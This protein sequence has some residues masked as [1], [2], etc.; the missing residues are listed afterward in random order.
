MS[1]EIQNCPH[2][3]EGRCPDDWE[4][5]APTSDRRV[6]QCHV[7]GHPVFPCRTRDDAL[8]LGR[9]GWR[10]ALA[11]EKP[12]AAVPAGWADRLP[13]CFAEPDLV[14]AGSPAV[15]WAAREALKA[16]VDARMT[17]TDV[18]TAARPF[19]QDRG[20]PPDRA[21]TELDKIGNLTT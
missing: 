1:A 18:L 13:H 8:F 19:L 3:A 14:W 12:P 11:G 16:A 10:V 6:H 21:R 2:R 5:M 9:H 17:M 4:A 20:V 15:R 7:C